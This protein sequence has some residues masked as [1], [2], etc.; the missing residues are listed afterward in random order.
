MRDSND[1]D[2][3]CATRANDGLTRRDSTTTGAD[4]SKRHAA[5]AAGRGE[6]DDDSVGDDAR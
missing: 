2:D 5:R 4:E 1:G 3:A 6:D